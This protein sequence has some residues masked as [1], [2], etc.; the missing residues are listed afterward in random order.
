VGPA[1]LVADTQKFVHKLTG[2]KAPQGWDNQLH[3][4]FVLS[5]IFERQQKY[6][7]WGDV[8]GLSLELIPH[9]GAGVG[10]VS[11][12]AATGAQIKFGW[13]LPNDF[14]ARL[15]RPGGS[16]STGIREKGPFG[17]YAFALIDGMAIAHNIFLDGN[18]F[19]ES[20]RVRKNPWTLELI[21]G[22]RARI[23]RFNFGYEHSFWSKRYKTESRKHVFGALFLAI[24]L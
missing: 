21:M 20:H 8:D 23:G 5:L 10:N 15:I 19:G 1:S 6:N 9:F 3:N 17:I 18:T 14:G 24:S 7:L 12:Y 11:I 4:E 13:K 16:R 22:L 2:A